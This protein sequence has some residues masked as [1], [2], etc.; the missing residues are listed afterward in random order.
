[1]TVQTW[2]YVISKGWTTHALS[3]GSTRWRVAYTEILPDEALAQLETDPSNEQVQQAY[4]RLRAERD[5]ILVADD[6]RGIVSGY[7][8]F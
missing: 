8:Y 7:S 2:K 4:E 3:S 5:G 1:M 6:D